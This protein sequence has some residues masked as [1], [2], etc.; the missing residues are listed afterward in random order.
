MKHIIKW[1]TQPAK[2][3]VNWSKSI[4]YGRKELRII[5]KKNPGLNKNYARKK[6]DSAFKKATREAEKE[7]NK[8]SN[9]DNLT[10][11]QVFDDTYNIDNDEDNA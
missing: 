3:S 8:T 9:I 11:K 1:F 5:Q 10:E 2:R 6:W 4:Q 7:M